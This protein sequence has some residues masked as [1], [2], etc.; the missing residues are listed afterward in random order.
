MSSD[1][2][3]PAET[4]ETE[5]TEDLGPP[6]KPRFGR[7]RRSKRTQDCLDD[8][9]RAVRR[10]TVAGL[11]A[12][13]LTF[14]QIAKAVEKARGYAISVGQV[15]RDWRQY[16]EELRATEHADFRAV[17]HEGLMAIC[18]GHIGK[19]RKGNPQSAMALERALK[20]HAEIFGVKVDRLHV[21][22]DVD[23]KVAAA[24]AREIIQGH[25]QRIVEAEETK[26]QPEASSE[27]V[28]DDAAGDGGSPSAAV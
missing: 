16:T 19:A 5:E 23:V 9:E 4:E 8:I 3:P 24:E 28:S 25:L 14:E 21:Q 27:T 18:E 20:T 7:G 13:G 1:A 15:Q 17:Y 26:P 2:P 10:K 22:A 12:K 11:R 6:T